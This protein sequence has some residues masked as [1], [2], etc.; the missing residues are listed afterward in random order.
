M[1]AI[2]V[3]LSEM[4]DHLKGTLKDAENNKATLNS[5]AP[6]A[7]HMIP[8]FQIGIYSSQV[9]KI[10]DVRDSRM[11]TLSFELATLLGSQTEKGK[12]LAVEYASTLDEVIRRINLLIPEAESLIRKLQD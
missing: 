11:S 4:L 3:E 5:N 12:I 9:G 6:E 8:I 1:G 10:K 7:F 2:R